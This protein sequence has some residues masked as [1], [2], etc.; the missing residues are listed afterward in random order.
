[1]NSE[2]TARTFTLAQRTVALIYGLLTHLFFVIGVGAMM[3]A[4][5]TGLTIGQGT[6]LGGRGLLANGILILQFPILHSF[7]LGPVGR[8]WMGRLTPLGLG[9]DL[10][11][12]LFAL[13]ASLQLTLVFLLWSP[14][15]VVWYRPQGPAGWIGWAIPY[16]A[17]WILLIKG[18]GD[19]GL[20]VQMGSLGWWAVFRGH[21]P[22]YQPFQVRGLY[23]YVR[24]PV[25]IAFALTL[26]T[27]AVWTPDRLGLALAWTV[28]CMLGPLFK[29]QR[30]RKHYGLAYT[31]Y[32]WSVPY[33]VP[34]RPEV[35]LAGPVNRVFRKQP[36][37]HDP[38][39]GTEVL[40]AGAGPVGLLLANLLG[41]R[42]VGVLLVEKRV[43][44]PDSSMAIGVTPPSLQVLQTLNL[45]AGLVQ[46]GVPIRRAVVHGGNGRLGGLGFDGLPGDYPFI[47]SVPQTETL[48]LLENNLQRFPSVR[49]I[50]GTEV[51]GLQSGD[52]DVTVRL[53]NSEGETQ[54]VRA[55]YLAA[56]D[57]HKGP[58]RGFLGIAADV[59]DYDLNFLMAD[60][61]DRSG[62]GDEAHLFF[63]ETGS[64]EAFPLPG[65]RRRWVVLTD[66][67]MEQA[68]DGFL[69]QTV[70]ARS[71]FDL[72]G[73]RKFLQTPFHVRRVLARRYASGRVVLCGDSAHVLSPIGGQ[74]MN[75]GF[76][77]A[78]FLAQVLV[79]L[80]REG[81]DAAELLDHYEFFRRRAFITASARAARGMWLGTQTGAGL[82]RIRDF[83][84]RRGL[85][86][87]PVRDR[88][89]PYFAML[90]IPFNTLARVPTLVPAAENR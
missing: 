36:A 29:E 43:S 17:S 19:A 89:P 79:I 48:R 25:Y 81:G 54:E 10:G 13:F 88:L 44:P 16:A 22:V 87:A 49:M 82:S 1:M 77:D 42:G 64:V 20:S 68:P 56:C 71:G 59:K 45:D 47:L 85:R 66:R 24:Q 11:T 21:A 5:Y 40:I 34:R 28:Y 57:G 63:T 35:A 90:T 78:E 4:L 74:G 84:I 37:P 52:K 14:S 58:I 67:F 69:E 38:A 75:T 2:A 12:T 7:F 9:R 23:K 70:K 41:A 6:W 46:R 51:V 55:G 31:L 27:G 72:A 76:A 3:V 18:M 32:Q 33:W 60:F 61:E 26:W 39:P 86:F 80:L 73:S 83:L 62:L 50:R 15:G 8:R 65:G 30:Y 53:K